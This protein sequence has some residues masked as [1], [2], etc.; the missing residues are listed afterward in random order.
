M[1]ALFAALI[2]L[3]AITVAKAGEVP[4]KV[5][6]VPVKSRSEIELYVARAAL[7]GDFAGVLK[8]YPEFAGSLPRINL[9]LLWRTRHGRQGIRLSL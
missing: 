6:E 9:F 2:L 3:G 8:H 4:V 1:Q 5:D 7:K